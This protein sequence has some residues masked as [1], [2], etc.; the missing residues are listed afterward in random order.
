M[1][2]MEEDEEK[3]LT[4]SRRSGRGQQQKVRDVAGGSSSGRLPAPSRRLWLLP[5]LLATRMTGAA[6]PLCCPWLACGGVA[7]MGS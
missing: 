7:E 1:E 3:E 5:A 2:G 6:P 4:G